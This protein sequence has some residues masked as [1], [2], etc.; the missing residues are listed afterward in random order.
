[1]L[2]IDEAHL[3]S[4][5]CLE[6]IRL[7]SNHE[8][9]NRKLIQI[10]LVG[11]NEIYQ[12]LQKNSLKSLKQRIVINRILQPLNKNE[13]EKYTKHRLRVAGRE[14]SLSTEKRSL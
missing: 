3:L 1:M 12:T 6:D 9:E 5:E 11:Q 14:E 13:V 7:L 4:E 10:V 2:I 8:A